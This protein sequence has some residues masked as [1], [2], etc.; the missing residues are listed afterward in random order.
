MASVWYPARDV[1]RYPLARWTP[2]APLRGLLTAAGFDPD[3]ATAPLTAGHQGAPLRR[4][5]ERWPVIVFSH[6]AHDHRSDTT[7]VVQE[8]A[9]HGYLVVTVDH[10]YDAFS[11][12]LQGVL[13]PEDFAHDIWFVLGRIEDLA[14]GRNPDAEHR[15]LAWIPPSI[16]MASACSAGRM[17]PQ[18]P[19]S[20]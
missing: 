15:P 5:A 4:A 3:A 2:A 9:S 10:T 7:V 8:L 12:L 20:S 19:P 17:A 1:W 13:Q 16:R 6:G 14:A 11:P 18:R